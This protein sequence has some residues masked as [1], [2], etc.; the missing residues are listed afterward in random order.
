[1]ADFYAGIDF[2]ALDWV[3]E[4]VARVVLDDELRLAGEGNYPELL[5]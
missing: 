3:L 5:H 2:K 4:A 1:V